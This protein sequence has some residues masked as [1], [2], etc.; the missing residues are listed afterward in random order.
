MPVELG[1][2]SFGFLAG[3]TIVAVVSHL[4][5]KSR[6]TENRSIQSFNSA[7]EDFRNILN[8]SIN[9]IDNGQ[10]VNDVIKA[11]FSPHRE[12]IVNG[13]VKVSQLRELKSV[14]IPGREFLNPGKLKS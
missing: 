13:N 6:D 14:P 8:A 5:T 10:Y 7:A 9:K 2:F 12:T 3:G 11:D 1:S 4:L